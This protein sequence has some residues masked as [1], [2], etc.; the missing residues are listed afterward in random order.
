MSKEIEKSKDEFFAGMY[1][2]NIDRLRMS[3]R[4]YYKDENDIDDLLQEVSLKA[5]KNIDQ[6]ERGSNEGA[7]LG[8]ILYTTFVNQYRK[9]KKTTMKNT[10]LHTDD[11][12]GALRFDVADGS[13]ERYELA[14][15]DE[16]AHAVN[17]VPE[18]LRVPFMLSVLEDFQYDEI[19]QILDVPVGTVRSRIHRARHMMKDDL[20][21]NPAFE[22]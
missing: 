22:R 4:R 13:F 20:E 1:A 17:K 11:E 3:A 9:H 21:S 19:A 10:S 16:F 8:F 2:R 6:F 14:L 12:E 5:Y 15:S 18:K 7:W